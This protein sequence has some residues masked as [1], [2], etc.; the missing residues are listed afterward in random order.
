MSIETI[1]Q[2]AFS[3]VSALQDASWD[4]TWA[5]LRNG[6]RRYMEVHWTIQGQF[7]STGHYRYSI[8]LSPFVG[9]Y[10]SDLMVKHYVY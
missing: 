1:L 9:E 3:I 7:V 8:L 4:R 6:G 2:N 10:M 5:G